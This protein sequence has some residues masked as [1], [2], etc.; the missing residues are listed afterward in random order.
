MVKQEPRDLLIFTLGPVQSF[1]ATARRTQD[2]W[3]GSR[4]LSSLAL[5]G[6]EYAHAHQADLVYPRQIENRWPQ[7]IPNRFVAFLPAGQGESLGPAVANA[8]AQAW[9]SAANQVRDFFKELA[10]ESGWQEAWERQTQQ[11]LETYWIA[12]PWD[13]ADYGNAYRQASLALDARKQVRTFPQVAEPGETCTLCGL[14]QALYGRQE[15]RRKIR[16]FWDLI[17][18]DSHL[19][20][21]ELREGEHLCAVCTIKRFAARAGVR[22][23]RRELKPAE[24]FPST[25]SVATATFQAQLLEN[26]TGLQGPILVHLNAL[27]ALQIRGGAAYAQPEASPF[28]RR[29]AEGETNA[30]RLLH[31][32][33]DF[34]YREGFVPDRLADLLGREANAQDE[35]QAKAALGSLNAL[36]KAASELDIAPPH[37]YLAVLVL[38]GD[39]MGQMLGQCQTADAHRQIS[40]A[41]VAFA[42]TQTPRIIEQEHAGRLV[43]AGGDDVLAL[44]PVDHALDAADQLS[45]AL[46]DALERAGQPERTASAG[47]CFMHH[48]HPL[49]SALR[50]AR[51]AEKLAKSSSAYNRNALVVEALRR[52]GEISRV[53][54]NWSYEGGSQD[55][56]AIIEQ[57]RALFAKGTLSSKIAYDLRQEAAALVTTP[58]AHQLELARLLRRHW[59]VKPV[60]AHRDEIETLAGQLAKLC[61]KGRVGIE[62]LAEWLLLARFLAH[63]GHE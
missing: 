1:I 23:G 14:R 29:L 10:P 63:G 45:Q 27:D 38:D 24:R 4:L 62:P 35:E 61:E 33:G 16:L 55:A 46:T 22:I 19:S 9:S 3:L 44:L 42:Q 50:T 53:G 60:E 15:V 49:E 41:L 31:Y 47:I 28:L 6:V 11:W 43:Y 39:R 17:R 54:L 5:V 58:A 36:L 8:V 2:L 48:T 30:A 7:S 12:W 37:A 56:L 18:Q 34:F 51:A 59:Q 13:G 26:W 25:S 40:D 21:T 52:S 32:D 57:V 20:S